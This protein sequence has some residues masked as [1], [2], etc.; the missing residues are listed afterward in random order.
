M[1]VM[2]EGNVKENI[3]QESV[4]DAN[5]LSEL[6]RS[7]SE[8]KKEHQFHSDNIK[9]QD[10]SGLFVRIDQHEVER[11]KRAK[12][13]KENKAI[14]AERAQKRRESLKKNKKKI[15]LAASIVVLAVVGTIAGI[16][17]YQYADEQHRIYE[18]TRPRSIHDLTEDDK[19]IDANYADAVEKF[20]E[21]RQMAGS[22]KDDIAEDGTLSTAYTDACKKAE[23]L[24]DGAKSNTEKIYFVTLYAK[25]MTDRGGDAEDALALLDKYEESLE[26][27]EE[28]EIFYA[29]HIPVYLALHDEENKKKYQ[30][31]YNELV[32]KR[33]SRYTE[34]QDEKK[35]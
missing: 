18:E 30:E 15:I 24:I 2:G 28:R 4:F 5:E 6:E 19:K 17:I 25:F 21:V 8:A 34:Y 10:N 32:D 3:N 35:N 12:E 20:K 7:E 27:D 33:L 11:I 29:A 22:A 9:R 26:T 13:K 1:S 31:L 16:K 14:L 23:E